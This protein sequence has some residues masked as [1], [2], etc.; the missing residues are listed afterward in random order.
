[1]P[2][3]HLLN[4]F[5]H[6]SDPNWPGRKFIPFAGQ[7]KAS[8]DPSN[9]RRGGSSPKSRHGPSLPAQ[10]DLFSRQ[11]KQEDTDESLDL[12][13]HRKDRD[14]EEDRSRDDHLSR[15]H[16]PTETPRRSSPPPRRTEYMDRRPIERT[17]AG[18]SRMSLTVSISSL[19]WLQLIWSSQ[20]G[21]SKAFPEN[22]IPIPPA[23]PASTR[24]TT[25]AV[26]AS[27]SLALLPAPSTQDGACRD[28]VELFRG[29][30][31]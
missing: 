13:R 4:S 2:T 14:A 26:T 31:K 10:S 11:F 18:S 17:E 21:L 28:M 3:N 8:F 16:R 25:P 27:D 1:M 24:K 29:L 23:G 22:G 9:A 15:R 30:A 12:L 19:L 6:P 20:N 5:V 7:K